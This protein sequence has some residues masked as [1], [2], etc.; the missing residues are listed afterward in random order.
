MLLTKEEVLELGLLGVGEQHK[1]VDDFLGN[2]VGV[3]IGSSIFRLQND[4]FEG[5]RVKKS[6][7]CG[8]TKDEMD[9]PVIVLGG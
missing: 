5:K 1:K 8:L 3:A 6:T 2:Y 4:Y 9:V 7:H